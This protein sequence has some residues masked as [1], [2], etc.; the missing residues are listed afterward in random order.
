MGEKRKRICHWPSNANSLILLKLK[1]KL[2]LRLLSLHPEGTRI[3]PF[4]CKLNQA[5]AIDVHGN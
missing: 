4:L 2:K 5:G 3:V 1:L